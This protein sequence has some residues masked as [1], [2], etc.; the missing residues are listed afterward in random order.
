VSLVNRITLLLLLLLLGCG[1]GFGLVLYDMTDASLGRQ[2]EERKSSRLGWLET[3]VEFDGSEIEFDAPVEPQ[4]AAEYWRVSLPDGKTLWASNVRKNLGNSLTERKLVFGSEGEPAT[5][6]DLFRQPKF[7]LFNLEVKET[8]LHP[9]FYLKKDSGR[10]VLVLEAGTSSL[11]M[12]EE[13][14]RLKWMLWILGPAA[15]AVIGLLVTVLLKWQLKPLSEMAEQ[16]GGIGP[17][18]P[19]ARME[20]RG[21]SSE[22]LRLREAMNGM[23]Q[24]L[25][26]GMKRERSFTSS[27]AHELRTPL[28]QMKLDIEVALRRDRDAEEYRKVLLELQ[29]DVDRLGGLTEGL[30]LLARGNNPG[31]IEGKPVPIERLVQKIRDGWPEAAVS[32]RFDEGV[33]VMGELALLFSVVNN[34]LENARRYAPGS[35]VE[36][37]VACGLEWVTVAVSDS[38]KG[39]AEGDR[40]R[41]FEPLT[42]LDRA[43]TV[44]GARGGY[45]LGLA[46]A[47]SVAR[48]FGGDVKCMGRTDGAS[49][50]RFEV[51]MR[52]VL[53]LG[54]TE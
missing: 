51:R 17:E 49:G 6:R 44:T 11:P 34:I 39:I 15:L 2:L 13:L 18:N 36:V 20:Y 9:P 41:A 31:G 42:R 50:A 16:A 24:R 25:S 37:E 8:R 38:G 35:G 28:A 52:R 27:A 26:E 43:R 3:A 33:A 12:L 32:G 5:G 19:D 53:P 4:E 22:C 23:L 1:L 46:V 14:V 45:G 40:E 10:L 54:E 47:R 29:E 7:S 48:A 21:S 30:L